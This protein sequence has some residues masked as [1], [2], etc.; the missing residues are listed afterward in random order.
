VFLRHNPNIGTTTYVVNVAPMT[1]IV[2]HEA[3]NKEDILVSSLHFPSSTFIDLSNYCDEDVSLH[4]GYNI[5][6]YGLFPSLVLG[7]SILHGMPLNLN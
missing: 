3:P 4:V 2:K 5:N 7:V 1:F 6:V